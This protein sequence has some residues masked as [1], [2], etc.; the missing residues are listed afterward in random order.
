MYGNNSS[1]NRSNAGQ[2]SYWPR[3]TFDQSATSG[4]E[5]GGQN[6]FP[7]SHFNSRNRPSGSN[8]PSQST[9]TQ[10]NMQQYGDHYNSHQNQSTMKVGQEHDRSSNGAMVSPQN[11]NWINNATMFPLGHHNSFFHKGNNSIYNPQ[12]VS[13]EGN[14]I[15]HSGSYEGITIN[16]SQTLPYGHQGQPFQ[17][18]NMSCFSVDTTGHYSH[19]NFQPSNVSIYPNQMSSQT[20]STPQL[21]VRQ[22]DADKMWLKHW[23][24][25]RH[26][27][28]T[29]VDEPRKTLKVSLDPTLNICIFTEREN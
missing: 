24:E 23:L 25:Q 15:S 7:K 14:T 10:R 3:G 28:T 6:A 2:Q 11:V 17:Q 19:S 8:Y 12:T 20:D 29:N 4:H 13:Y 22:E 27:Q 18:K 1:R 5:H 9:Y 21:T 26:I 16:Q